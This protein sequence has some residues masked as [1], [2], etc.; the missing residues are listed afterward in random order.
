MR[1]IRSIATGQFLGLLLIII[2]AISF[3]AMPI[4]ARFAYEAG[5]DT[6]TVLFLRFVIA[7]GVMIFLMIIRRRSFPRGRVLLGLV[8]LGALGYVGESFTY[9]T[10]LT[11]ASAGMVALLL[12][13]YPAI[14]ALLAVIIL[15]E[16]LTPVRVGALLLAL[17]GTVLTIRLTEG[18][19]LPGIILSIIAALIYAIYILIGS[20]FVPKAGAIPAATVVMA[21]AA[22][23][24]TGIIAVHGTTFPKT[25]IGWMAVLAIALISTV[26]AFV[27]FFAG[28]ERIG[29]ISTSTISTFEPVVAVILAAF[30]L[31][32]TL[33]LLQLLGG[34]LILT[35]VVVLARSQAKGKKVDISK[36]KL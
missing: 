30:L 22:I 26:L 16:H 3:G 31:G 14:V 29:P 21:S 23:V 27:T 28:L 34:V 2:S 1:S 6:L 8:L 9:F 4:F 35:A 20:R 25:T 19:Q 12:Y 36:K 18:G 15:H 17:T 10:A 7:A 13:L 32:E 33:N 5:T 24:Y 11:M